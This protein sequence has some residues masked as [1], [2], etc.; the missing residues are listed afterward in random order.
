M[1][2]GPSKRNEKPR[3]GSSICGERDAE[4]EQHAVDAR[5][6]RARRG[7]RAS[8]E[9]HARRNAKRGSS[10]AARGRVGGGI[11]VDATSRPRGPSAR[12]HRA[13]VAA[14]AERAH[15]RR[16]P[17]GSIA[18][19]A[20]A[21]SSRTGTCPPSAIR[22]RSRRARAAGRPP[23]TR[24]PAPSAPAT[25]LVPQLELAALPDEHDVLVEARVAAQRGRDQDAPGRV[26]LDVVGV[27]DEQP[28]QRRGSARRTTRAP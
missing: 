3:A 23:G 6:C 7:R 8:S 1:S 26:D 19:A 13:R 17:S 22:A 18:S 5:R 11:A 10:M 16:S 14:A 2:S 28:L 4:V 24:S 25:A 21:S 12:E 15:R 9:N 27:T 20:T